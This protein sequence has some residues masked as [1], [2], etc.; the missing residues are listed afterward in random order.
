MWWLVA[1][2][3]IGVFYDAYAKKKDHELKMKQIEL[4][5]KQLEL[6]YKR[7][8]RKEQSEIIEVVDDVQEEKR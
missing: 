1:I 3:A 2:I 5:K 6:E 8:K 4:E 7:E